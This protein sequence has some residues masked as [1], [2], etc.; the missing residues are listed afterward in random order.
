MIVTYSVMHKAHVC[1]TMP[2]VARSQDVDK[3][4]VPWYAVAPDEVPV[5]KEQQPSFQQR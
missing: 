3:L 1:V 4:H 2:L 5:R